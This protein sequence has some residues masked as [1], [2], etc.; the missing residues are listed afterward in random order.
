VSHHTRIALFGGS[1]AGRGSAVPP[2]ACRVERVHVMA[3]LLA[4]MVVA[5]FFVLLRS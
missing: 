2:A 5:V 1:L 3:A 4:A